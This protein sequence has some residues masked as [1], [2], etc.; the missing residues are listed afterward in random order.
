M[1]VGSL[2]CRHLRGLRTIRFPIGSATA[3]TTGRVRAVDAD[4]IITTIAAG[5]TNT[6]TDGAPTTSVQQ[7]LPT[8]IAF[9]RADGS[10]VV[11]DEGDHRVR[12]LT[13]AAIAPPP[14]GS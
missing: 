4:G 5:G 1:L 7:H 12:R 13:P 3:D 9:D 6:P 14:P 10:P 2:C 8:S 11:G